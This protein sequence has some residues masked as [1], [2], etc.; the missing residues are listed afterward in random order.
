MASSSSAAT[1][2]AHSNA[3]DSEGSCGT[4]ASSTTGAFFL[5]PDTFLFAFPVCAFAWFL[6]LLGG[7]L[8]KRNASLGYRSIYSHIRLSFELLMHFKGT[9]ALS[10]ARVTTKR[11]FSGFPESGFLLVL[12]CG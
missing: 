1:A 5:G 3:E 11:G 6:F 4:A 12:R 7:E 8:G 9:Y 2:A 10:K